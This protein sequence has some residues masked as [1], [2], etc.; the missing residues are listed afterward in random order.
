[1][2]S[3]DLLEAL[4]SRYGDLVLP[5][6]RVNVRLSES[7]ALGKTIYEYDPRSRGAIDYAQLVERLSERMSLG[8]AAAHQASPAARAAPAP[9][10]LAPPPPAREPAPPHPAPAD[11][12]VVTGAGSMLS[13]SC[14]HCGRPLQRATVAGYRVTYC[15]NCKYR[16]QDLASGG[17]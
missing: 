2:Q 4:R 12:P 3:V 6:I 16:H 14:P 9:P 17:R 13:A 8:P 7:S 10:A 15:D 5:P 1:R 11:Q